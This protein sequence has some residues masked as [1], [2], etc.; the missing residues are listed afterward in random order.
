M[1][2]IHEVTGSI[3]V[4]STSFASLSQRTQPVLSHADAPSGRSAG[5]IPVWSIRCQPSISPSDIVLQTASLYWF[6]LERD[7]SRRV[8]T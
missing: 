5:A 7:D 6:T 4:W 3:P 1:N 2:G 8:R